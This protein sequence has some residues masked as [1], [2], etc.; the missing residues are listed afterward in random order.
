[1]LKSALVAIAIIL[2]V[3]VTVWITTSRLTPPVTIQQ[4]IDSLNRIDDSLKHKQFLL[5]SAINEHE[6]RISGMEDTISKIKS[7]TV[8]INRHYHDTITYIDKFGLQQLDSFFK[9]RYSY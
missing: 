7:N 1:M 2:T 5:D 8:I 9:K 6:D 4:Q 3:G